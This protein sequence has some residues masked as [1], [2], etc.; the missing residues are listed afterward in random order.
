MADRSSRTRRSWRARRKRKRSMGDLF[1]TVPL[2]RVIIGDRVREE[3]GDIERLAGSIRKWGQLFPVIVDQD[4]HLCDGG[5]RLRALEAAGEATVNVSVRIL[6]DD[7]RQE[8]ELEIDRE[9]K[10]LTDYERSKRYL[11]QAYEAETRLAEREAQLGPNEKPNSRGGP[12]PK[13]EFSQ[14]EIA[15]EAGIGRTTL[16]DAEAHVLAVNQFPDL[17]PLSQKE[18]IREARKE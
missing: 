10:S 12:K 17:A 1:E 5:R 18:A 6:T 2:A 3:Y 14:R 15:R 7:E 8:L 11:K 4:Y 16:Q 9:H 13:K